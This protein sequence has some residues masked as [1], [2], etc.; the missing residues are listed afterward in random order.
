V[1][2]LSDPDCGYASDGGSGGGGRLE[3][4]GLVFT[5]GAPAR[6]PGPP[7]AQL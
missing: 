6:A 4:T 3:Q 5:M 2:V 1:E 7:F